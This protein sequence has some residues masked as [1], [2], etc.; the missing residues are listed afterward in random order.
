MH[1]FRQNLN[2]FIEQG[3]TE[4][5]LEALKDEGSLE[6]LSRGEKEPH[7]TELIKISKKLNQSL[8][9][10]AYVDLKTAADKG[11]DIKAFITDIDGVMTDGGM[12][13]TER[14]DELKKF[15]TKDGLI[16]KKLLRE[17]YLVGFLSSGTSL[18][19]VEERAKMLGVQK[20]YAGER[21]KS[22]VFDEWVKEW[23]LDY[24]NI[25]YMGDDLNDKHV[26]EKAGFKACPADAT[27]AIKSRVDLV[28]DKGGGKGCV[29][30]FA[31][32]YLLPNT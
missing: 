16:L 14:G 24:S 3:Y 5:L 4:K 15:N 2:H 27:E 11:S 29:R 10:L 25:A 32:N 8:E 1:H 9:R 30:E 22:E 7:L 31:E 23:G 19:L 20:Y 21:E 12:I 17:D 6:K 13:Y 18:K 28:M 26:F